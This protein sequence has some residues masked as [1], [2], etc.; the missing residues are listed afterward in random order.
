MEGVPGGGAPGDPGGTAILGDQPPPGKRLGSGTESRVHHPLAASTLWEEASSRQ[1]RLGGCT[2]AAGAGDPQLSPA[3]FPCPFLL[4]GLLS[5]AEPVVGGRGK[6][7]ITCATTPSAAIAGSRPSSLRFAGGEGAQRRSCRG[8]LRARPTGRTVEGPGDSDQ[9]CT[10]VSVANLKTVCV[11]TTTTRTSPSFKLG[12]AESDGDWQP[13]ADPR[14][15]GVAIGGARPKLQVDR[16]SER[17]GS[18]QRTGPGT[19]SGQV[20]GASGSGGT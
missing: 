17:L 7:L 12:R 11:R 10:R 2:F 14:R 16:G 5:V 19:R 13:A 4:H 1:L 6:Y 20:T 9:W 8:I 18:S 15:H 3:R